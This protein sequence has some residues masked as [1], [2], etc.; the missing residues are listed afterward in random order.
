MLIS[1]L[2]HLAVPC[3]TDKKSIDLTLC[4][5]DKMYYL[6]PLSVI[7][8]EPNGAVITSP[9]LYASFLFIDKDMSDLFKNKKFSSRGLPNYIVNTLLEN[10]II[11][12]EKSEETKYKEIFSFENGLPTQALFEVTSFCNCN[13]ITCYHK[14]DLNNHVPDISDLKKRVLKLKE[15][16]V[17][18]FEVTGGEPFSRPDLISILRFI[19]EENLLYY[20]VT[21]GAFLENSSKE[22]KEI[23]KTSLGLAISL[24]GIGETHDRIRHCVGLYDKMISGVEE[25]VSFGVKVYFISTL[26]VENLHQIKQLI[27]VAERYNTTVHFRPTINTGAAAENCLKKMDI[28][29]EIGDLLYHPNVRNGLLKTKK[30]VHE[31]RYYGCGLRKRISVDSFGILYPCVMDRTRFFNNV[32]KQN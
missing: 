10:K 32:M 17:G 23:L 8:Y 24:D 22:L 12:S 19:K 31:S 21:N 25:M 3:L 28:V 30:S 11:L 2:H 1:N 7:R 9:M 18:L 6:N 4:Q 13:C 5:D 29:T 15:L 14:G 27:K 16:G 20:I 26:N